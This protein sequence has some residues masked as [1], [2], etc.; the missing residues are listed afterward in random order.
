MKRD[1]R[2]AFL[3]VFVLAS[4]SFGFD[5]DLFWEWEQVI[6]PFWRLLLVLGGF[7]FGSAMLWE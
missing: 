4:S 2:I 3:F 5:F 6:V 1:E 7:W